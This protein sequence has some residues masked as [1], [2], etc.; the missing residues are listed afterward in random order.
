MERTIWKI[1]NGQDYIW[2]WINFY[3]K[4]EGELVTNSSEGSL[5]WIKMD[6]LLSVKQF[7]QNENFTPFLFKDELFEGKFLLDDKS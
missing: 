4:T 2:L 6:D 5:E 7:E 3:R 1:Y